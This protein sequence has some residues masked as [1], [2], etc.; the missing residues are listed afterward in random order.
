MGDA[1]SRDTAEQAAQCYRNPVM[2][3]QQRGVADGDGRRAW[4]RH[5]GT[6]TTDNGRAEGPGQ[7]ETQQSGNQR[8]GAISAAGIASSSREQT[9][10]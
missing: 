6:V 8:Q 1:S 4:D 2:R 9:R 10:V 3:S 5:K 7:N